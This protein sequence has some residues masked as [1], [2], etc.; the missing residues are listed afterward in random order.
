[1]DDG[2]FQDNTRPHKAKDVAAFREENGLH[3]LSWPAQSPNLNPIENL[4]V[5]VKHNLQKN[6]PTLMILN[7]SEKGVAVD[8]EGIDREFRRFP[9]I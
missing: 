6:L 4:W 7:G 3:T 9:T 5:E 1:M 8:P 2:W